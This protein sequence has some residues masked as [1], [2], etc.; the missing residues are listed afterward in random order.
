[1]GRPAMDRDSKRSARRA[2]PLVGALERRVL[3]SAVDPVIN[4]FMASNTSG[5]SD[6]DGA[7]SDWIEIYNPGTAAVNLA[8]WHL[9]DDSALPHKFTFPSTVINPGGYLLVFATGV[10]QAIAGGE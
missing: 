10:E 7:K 3:M 2:I 8:G 9:T 1:M 5:I 6:E 4:E